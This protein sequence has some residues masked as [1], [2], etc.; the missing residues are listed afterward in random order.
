[1]RPLPPR[2]VQAGRPAVVLADSTGPAR[3]IRRR[4]GRERGVTPGAHDAALRG[5]GLAAYA[6]IRPP[7]DRRAPTGS[8]DGRRPGR[9]VRRKA[10]GTV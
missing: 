5:T 2:P 1:M 4:G 9:R 10:G 6:E 3:P 8:P 7:A